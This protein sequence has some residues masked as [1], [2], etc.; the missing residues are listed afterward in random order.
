[1]LKAMR[2]FPVWSSQSRTK[3]LGLPENYHLVSLRQQQVQ[4]LVRFHCGLH[5]PQMQCAMLLL[6]RLPL[7]VHDY[8]SI[9][10]IL[11]LLTIELWLDSTAPTV[12]LLNLTKHLWSSKYTGQDGRQSSLQAGEGLYEGCR[13]DHS[14]SRVVS[15]EGPATGCREALITG[16]AISTVL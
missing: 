5:S 2:A 6:P 14:R 13:Q 1:M 4:A 9:T 12:I 15:E 11:Q 16:K 3:Q 8:F 7:A 10:N